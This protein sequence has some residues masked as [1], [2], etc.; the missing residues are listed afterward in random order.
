MFA[1]NRMHEWMSSVWN[2]DIVYD[3]CI[4]FVPDAV[5]KEIKPCRLLFEPEMIISVHS[6][7]M[8]IE[9]SE[10]Q[11]YLINGSI[12]ER[13]PGSRIPAFDYDEFF[14][15]QPNEYNIRSA[16]VSGRYVMYDAGGVET[17]KRQIKV[18]YKKKN[19]F[20]F[21][22]ESILQYLPNTKRKLLDREDI[23]IL[24]YGDSF[25][26]GCDA[27]GKTGIMPYMPTL[28]RLIIYKLADFYDHEKIRF[29]NT[30]VGGTFAEW[31]LEHIK[32]KVLNN[33][34]DL[35][36]IRFGMND[37]TLGVKPEV[38]AIQMLQIITA[39][40]M[41][42]PKAECIILMNE[43]PNPDCIGWT[44]TQDE[45][46]RELNE[47]IPNGNGIAKIE[48]MD[49]FK[50]VMKVKGFEC[51]T[52]NFVNHPNDFMIRLYAQYVCAALGAQ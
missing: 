26:E 36:I 1:E 38:F 34:P 41:D 42:N 8:G 30:A 39:I 28:D 43:L 16:S 24:F 4:L 13:L 45:F 9:Y 15:I 18:T 17:I 25:M 5:S 6:D 52:S 37:G 33:K 12:V 50:H 44:K 47:R 3:E 11:D 10:G 49:M 35:V 20:P 14:R 2:E 32:D 51:I 29:T 46:E 48:I 40:R 23:H 22:P 27:S 19:R 21:F 7:Y 31:G